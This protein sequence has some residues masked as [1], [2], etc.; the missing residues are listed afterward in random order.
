MFTFFNGSPLVPLNILLD[1]AVTCTNVCN[2][3]M[4]LFMFKCL[5]QNHVSM[6]KYRTGT[7]YKC[8]TAY[9]YT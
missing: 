3:I 4:G 7:S 2:M 5:N 1:Q 9:Y 8:T 6:V